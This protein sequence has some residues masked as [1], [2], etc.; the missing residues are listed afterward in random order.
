MQRAMNW[1]AF[2][3]SRKPGVLLAGEFPVELHLAANLVQL[4]G[5][6][7]VAQGQQRAGLSKRCRGVRYGPAGCAGLAG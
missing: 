4:A 7:R 1:A 3:N 5:L 6:V 2:G